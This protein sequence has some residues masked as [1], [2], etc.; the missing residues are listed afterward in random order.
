MNTLQISRV[1]ALRAYKGTD[2]KGKAL[3]SDLLGE[4]VFTQNLTETLKTWEDFC[5]WYGED[6]VESLPFKS[7][8]NSRQKACNAFFKL[9]IISEV[10]CGDVVLDYSD[11]K[12]RKYYAWMQYTAGSGFAF[13]GCDCGITV[14]DVGSRL[15][16]DS[17]E[18][19]KYMATQFRELYNDLMTR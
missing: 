14:T 19:T 7:P 16:T 5:E 15:S 9:D 2:P 8:V 11:E 18:K 6:P 12:Q 13:Y 17:A 4:K 1:N 10:L 3:L